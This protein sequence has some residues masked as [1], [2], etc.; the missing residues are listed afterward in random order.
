MIGDYDE[1]IQSSDQYL[2]TESMRNNVTKFSGN[3]DS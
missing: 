1:Y 2:K 3:I